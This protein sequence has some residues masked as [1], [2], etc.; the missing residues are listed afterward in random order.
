MLSATYESVYSQIHFTSG[1]LL[2]LKFGE[3][4]CHGNNYSTEQTGAV[5]VVYNCI[6]RRCFVLISTMSLAILKED[7]LC[8]FFSPS[9]QISRFY[10][11]YTTIAFFPPNL[12][13]SYAP[14]V[15]PSILY[16][17]CV[18]V[19]VC[20]CEGMLNW[21]YLR[22]LFV[23]CNIDDF[24]E[25]LISACL[26]FVINY[27]PGTDMVSIQLRFFLVRNFS[28]SRSYWHGFGSLYCIRFPLSFFT[29]NHLNEKWRGWKFRKWSTRLECIYSSNTTTNGRYMYII[30][31]IKNNYMF[32][33]FSLAIFRLIHQ[34]T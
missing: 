8:F 32:R 2:L 22:M 25:T 26:Y 21:D 7:F 20:V 5:F 31:Y 11:D 29:Y 9:R 12:E 14:F 19:C 27:F 13:K 4:V 3:A 6:F 23:I 28:E 30:Y 34:K 15:L 24:M 18:C 16:F 1:R 17:V 33:P 10:V